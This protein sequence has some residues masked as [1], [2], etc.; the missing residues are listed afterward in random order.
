MVSNKTQHT[1]SHP[2]PAIHCLYILYF[3]EG[4]EEWEGEPERRLEG[5]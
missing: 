3:W 4:G 5:Q 2:L 1:P